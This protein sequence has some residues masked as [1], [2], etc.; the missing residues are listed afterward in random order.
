[1]F[2]MNSGRSLCTTMA[3]HR[4]ATGLH[5]LHSFPNKTMTD[6]VHAGNEKNKGRTILCVCS[7]Y[8]SRV[9]DSGHKAGSLRY[10]DLSVHCLCFVWTIS[11][12]VLLHASAALHLLIPV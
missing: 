8:L 1:M 9:T 4:C 2:R 11:Q 10:A 3:G 5:V 12:E 6:V 7:C